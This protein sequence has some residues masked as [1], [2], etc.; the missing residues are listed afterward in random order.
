MCLK[1]FGFKSN[2]FKNPVTAL[3]KQLMMTTFGF[4]EGT[5]EP[6]IDKYFQLEKEK[7]KEKTNYLGKY[8]YKY[9]Y[10]ELAKEDKESG[11]KLDNE[12]GKVDEVEEVIDTKNK[13]EVESK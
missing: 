8:F 2:N 6:L 1:V 13:H 10:K 4:L 11:N 7:N 3:F 5:L 9:F 12:G